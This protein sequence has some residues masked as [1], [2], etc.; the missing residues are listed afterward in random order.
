MTNRSISFELTIRAPSHVVWAVLTNAREMPAL[1]E[2]TKEVHL[3]KPEPGG[4]YRL[5]YEG[6]DPADCEILEVDLGKRL[7]FRLQSTTPEPI[8]VE[9]LLEPAGSQTGVK[10]TSGGYKEGTRWDKAHDENFAGWLNMFLGIRKMLEVA[11]S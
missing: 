8:T 4:I 1:W 10:F 9:Y 11:Q 3:T 7:L 2:G 6:S 5:D